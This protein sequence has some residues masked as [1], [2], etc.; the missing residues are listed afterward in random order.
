LLQLGDRQMQLP[1]SVTARLVDGIVERNVIVGI[2]PEHVALGTPEE[3]SVLP[4]RIDLVEAMGAEQYAYETTNVAVP[5]LSA[6]SDTQAVSETFVARIDADQRLPAAGSVI[7]LRLDLDEIHLFDPISQRTMTAPVHQQLQETQPAMIPF[8]NAHA[9]PVG[10]TIDADT[11]A[12]AAIFDQPVASPVA[13]EP[14]AVASGESATYPAAGTR[15]SAVAT[16]STGASATD[17][18]SVTIDDA[19]LPAPARPAR[20]FAPRPIGAPSTQA[21]APREEQPRRRPSLPPVEA[22]QLD[23]AIQHLDEA[24]TSP[25]AFRAALATIQGTNGTSTPSGI[26]VRALR[27]SLSISLPES[28]RLTDGTT[29][30]DP[31]QS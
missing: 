12:V 2:R 15:P 3:Q 19:P 16:W 24:A 14:L 22:Q 30:A 23:D 17:G 20:G 6:L 5:D 7:A 11:A 9:V 21:Q 8:D 10:S 28:V 25:S 13:L 1:A 27:P 18:G 4:G 29:G 26:S 31:T